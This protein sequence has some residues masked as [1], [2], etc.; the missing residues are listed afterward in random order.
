VEYFY[1]AFRGVEKMQGH[2]IV[3]PFEEEENETKAEV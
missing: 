1:A 3:K 2:R